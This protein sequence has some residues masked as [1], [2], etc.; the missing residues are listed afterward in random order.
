MTQGYRT[1]RLRNQH[2]SRV[3]PHDPQSE[4]AVLGAMLV[5]E[6]ALSEIC[7]ESGLV[8]EDFYLEI[9]RTVF[10]AMVR[11]FSEG[12]PVDKVTVINALGAAGWKDGRQYVAELWDSVP[13][14][15]NALQYAKA[16]R[17]AGIYRRLV[18]AG[19]LIEDIG[20]SKDDYE[21]PMAAVDAAERALLRAADVRE[22]EGLLSLEDLAPEAMESLQRRYES[23][24]EMLGLPSGLFDV[25]RLTGGAAPGDLLVL[26]ARPAMGKTS[27]A[28][29]WGWHVAGE[30]G[31][32]V[33]IFSLEMSREQLVDRILS[34]VSRVPVQKIRSGK[35]AQE[36]F[37]RLLREGERISKA[38]LFIDDSAGTTVPRMRAKLQRLQARLRAR[39]KRLGLVVVD[40]LQLM[41]TEKKP[42]DKQAE[43]AEISRSLKVL[44]RDLD[45]AVIAV[46][47]LNREVEHRHDK[48]P[49]LSDLRDSGAVEQDADIVM[50]LYRDEYYNPDS[51][52]KGT[53]EV[54][55]GKHRNGPTGKETVAWFEKEARFASIS[56]QGAPPA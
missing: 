38:P 55:V 46:A 30:M 23:D 6:K 9:H 43:V 27:M 25:D 7:G 15:S 48:R 56:R 32:P 2:A 17:E 1:G 29:G 21:D 45:V 5:S 13:L 35:V 52:S 50:F 18:D 12:K 41:T 54:I 47:Q 11:V 53:A 42:K 8:T 10:D 19:A 28:L 3:P 33:A 36:D 31:E 37:P 24:G 20:F 44:A 40:Y 51:D 49:L 34:S 26:A 39:G 14:A 16:V 22:E 4:R